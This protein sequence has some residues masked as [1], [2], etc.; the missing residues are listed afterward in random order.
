MFFYFPELKYLSANTKN[1]LSNVR[2]DLIK[3]LFDIHKKENM[4]SIPKELPI[5]IIAGDK[6]PVGRQGK[7]IL[8][9]YDRY[10]KLNIKDVNYKLYEN[11]RHEILNE[12]NKDEVIDDILIWMNGIL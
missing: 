9:L 10:K 7:G 5:Y 4:E 2:A 8:D 6:D 12:I 11:G 3:G 1:P